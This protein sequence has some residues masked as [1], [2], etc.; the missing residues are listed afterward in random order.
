MS[1][2]NQMLQDLD[3]RGSGAVAND[4]SHAQIRAVSGQSS[5]LRLVWCAA[6]LLTA[7][8]T[9]VIGW[10]FWRQAAPAPAKPV[11]SVQPAQQS[12]LPRTSNL[13]MSL[14][15]APDQLALQ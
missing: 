9:A 15:I 10:L 12:A 2:I 4:V 6:L 11:A 3:K 5:K 13:G 7:I 14:S 8:L 1:L